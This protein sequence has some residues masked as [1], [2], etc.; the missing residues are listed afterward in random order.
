MASAK[1]NLERR[2]PPDLIRL[3]L[4]MYDGRKPNS[5]IVSTIK[6][7]FPETRFAS[8][9]IT[10]ILKA[11]RG[12]TLT[13]KDVGGKAFVVHFDRDVTSFLESLP[14]PVS[15]FCNAILGIYIRE[16]E[17]KKS[18]QENKE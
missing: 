17:L 6:Y 4:D 3:V 5:E 13:D 7:I 1:D 2:F 15:D 9:D 16:Y 8:N 10:K 11:Y 18:Q 14:I 12:D